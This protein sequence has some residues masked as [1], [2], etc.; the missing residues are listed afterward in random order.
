[1]K[2][3]E[4]E[5]DGGKEK[6]EGC[7]SHIGTPQSD[8]VREKVYEEKLRRHNITICVVKCKPQ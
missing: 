3:D 1:M 4:K 6:S 8:S 2:C 5:A 7:I